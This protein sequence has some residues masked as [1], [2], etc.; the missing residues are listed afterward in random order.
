MFAATFDDF[1]RRCEKKNPDMLI[2]KLVTAYT[3]SD[4]F[5][6]YYA[7]F[8]SGVN[9]KLHVTF[10]KDAPTVATFYLVTAKPKEKVNV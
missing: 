1:K 9:D 8:E 5:K 2:K 6:A 3:H 10:E 4:D 7:V